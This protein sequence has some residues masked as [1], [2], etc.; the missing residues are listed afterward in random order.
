MMLL[1]IFAAILACITTKL[2]SYFFREGMNII[3]LL[4]TICLLAA[5]IL[6]IGF[7]KGDFNIPFLEL[8]LK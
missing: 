8:L 2:I 3:Q 5:T 7:I 4:F 6:L 1:F